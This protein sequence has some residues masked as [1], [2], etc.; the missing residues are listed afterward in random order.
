MYRVKTRL[1]ML[2]EQHSTVE[3]SLP[4]V[5]AVAAEYFALPEL[6]YQEK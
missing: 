4:V 2:Y 6:Q 3:V 5:A 1:H